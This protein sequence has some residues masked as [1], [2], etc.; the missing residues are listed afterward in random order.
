MKYVQHILYYISS[1]FRPNKSATVRFA[2]PLVFAIAAF[3]GAA[4]IV[5]DTKSFIHLESSVASVKSGETFQIGIY[6]SAHVPVNAVN[7]SLE[8]PKEQIKVVSIDKGQS[9][10]T[11]WT[12]EPHVEG[13]KV[14]LTGGTFRRG[15]VGDH[16]IATINAKA[17][18]TGLAKFSVDTVDLLAGD[19]SGSKVTVTKTDK[20]SATL[21]IS[22]ADGTALTSTDAVGIKG[23]ASVVI[24]TDI[25]GDGKV[26]LAD[27]S[28]FMSAWASKNATFDFNGDGVM[29]FRDFGII[30]SDSFSR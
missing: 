5:P 21:V 25:D 13:N 6:V 11:L 16:L 20:E 29:S 24:V 30:L 8:F 2:F 12:E 27:I 7:I 4:A 14:S 17:I 15:F 3:L 28:R 18:Q 22:S 9:V 26:T 10:L 19:G 1:C 23:E